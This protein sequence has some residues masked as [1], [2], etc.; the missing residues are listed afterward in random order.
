MVAALAVAAI[1]ISAAATVGCDGSE[2]GPT[3]HCFL[4]DKVGD[5]LET[6]DLAS[7]C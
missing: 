3:T 4:P 5:T 2:G 7:N 6:K 1:A